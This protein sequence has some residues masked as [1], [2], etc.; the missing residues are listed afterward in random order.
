MRDRHNP[1]SR[2]SA[3]MQAFLNDHPVVDFTP[4][5]TTGALRKSCRQGN[6][7][8]NNTISNAQGHSLLHPG[9][10]HNFAEID[11]LPGDSEVPGNSDLGVAD[12]LSPDDHR[13][14]HNDTLG[15]RQVPSLGIPLN[16]H[17]PAH[18][19][20]A[21]A[22]ANGLPAGDVE[23]LWLQDTIHLDDIRTATESVRRLQEA[24]LDD[25][26]LRMSCEALERLRNPL[27][28]QPLLSINDD[29]CLALEMYLGNPSEATT[30]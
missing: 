22:I 6:G 24:S 16:D 28:E 10:R 5:P 14:S 17:Q 18:R 13:P 27:L 7:V 20:H 12:L 9:Q 21:S 15:S 23:D 19:S 29:T 25:P 1:L 11:T 2:F 30:R 4:S 3:L 26:S 8:A